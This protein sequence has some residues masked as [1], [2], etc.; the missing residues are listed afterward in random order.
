MRVKV[1]LSESESES[2]CDQDERENER[3]LKEIV[4]EIETETV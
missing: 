2:E 4:Y 1:I 3:M